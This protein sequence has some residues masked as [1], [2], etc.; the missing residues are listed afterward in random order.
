MPVELRHLRAFLAI[1]ESLNVTRAAETLHVTQPALTRTLQQLERQVGVQLVERSTHH[2][3]LTEV[4]VAFRDQAIDV[5]ASFDELV[6]PAPGPGSPL[7][8]GHAWAAFGKWSDEVVRRWRADCP[9]VPLE[10]NRVDDRYAGLRDR[11]VDVAILR[12]APDT[13]G[14]HIEPLFD[15]PRLVALPVGHPLA[16][17]TVLTLPDL[18]SDPVVIN[19]V[20]GTTKLSLWGTGQRPPW[21]VRVRN[22]DDWIAAISS[23]SGLGVTAAS[24]AH[25]Y[26]YP[27]VVYRPLDGVPPIPVALAWPLR[28][29]H[30]STARFVRL[31]R[32]V[33]R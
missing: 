17:R 19:T 29:P 11:R 3:A 30:P 28:A 33:M 25:M 12:G 16:A 1:A 18:T 26:P 21:K 15:E 23:G 31:V 14:I 22:T 5:V 27:G 13:P 8:V 9:E 2:V 7:R 24:T 4:G 32:A 20:S 10:V 6:A